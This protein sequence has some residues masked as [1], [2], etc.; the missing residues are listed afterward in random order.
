MLTGME[1]LL[2]I[3]RA[4]GFAI[5]AFNVYNAETALGVIFAAEEIK[6]CVI[7]TCTAVC[8]LAIRRSFSRRRWWRLR[9]VQRS[10]WPYI[11]ITEPAM[12]T[13]SGR[14]AMATPAL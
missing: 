14:C 1:K 3:T 6:A 12:K 10:G 8:S 5:P 7:L 9:S 2:D 4:W 11:W 13:L